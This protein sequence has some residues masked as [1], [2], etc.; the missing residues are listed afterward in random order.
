MADCMFGQEIH[1][2]SLDVCIVQESEVLKRK[3]QKNK[4]PQ[5]LK[6]KTPHNGEDTSKG[7]NR[8]LK[9]SQYEQQNK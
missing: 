5:K 4:K 7:C 2:M 9:S 6:T 1:T 8:Q 3:K